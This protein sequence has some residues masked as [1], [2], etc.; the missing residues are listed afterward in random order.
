MVPP[1]KLQ[2]KA[3][4]TRWLKVVAFAVLYTPL[5]VSICAFIFSLFIPAFAKQVLA[6]LV[7]AGPLVITAFVPS[8]RKHLVQSPRKRKKSNED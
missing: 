4:V 1:E 8:V 6:Y 2:N 7:L 3:K 5:A